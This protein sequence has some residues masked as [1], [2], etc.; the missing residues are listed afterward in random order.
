MKLK[1]NIPV[2]VKCL[3]NI[4]VTISVLQQ[5]VLDVSRQNKYTQKAISIPKG[6][7]G[8]RMIFIIIWNILL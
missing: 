8:L 2:F 6:G 3:Q 1:E 5:Q 7:S 4:M